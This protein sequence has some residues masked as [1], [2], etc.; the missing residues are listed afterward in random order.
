MARRLFGFKKDTGASFVPDIH[1]ESEDQEHRFQRATA[2]NTHLLPDSTFRLLWD[3]VLFLATLYNAVV[4]PL[5]LFVFQRSYE[6]IFTVDTVLDIFFV[7]AT[8][9][10]FFLYYVDDDTGEIITGQ[11]EIRART[12]SSASFYI[13]ATACLPLL[14]K[15]I[16]SRV[17]DDTSRDGLVSVYV[18]RLIRIYGFPSQFDQLK[19]LW[20]K[21][22]PINQSLFRVNVMYFYNILLITMFGCVYFGLSSLRVSTICPES[23]VF[24]DDILG[25]EMW[26]AGDSVITDVMNP[27]VC[28]KTRPD[29][30]C[31]KCPESLFFIRSVYFLVQTFFTIG[32][33]DSVVP[34]KSS[35]VEMAW[36]CFCML[37][38][39][40]MYSLMIANMSSV[41][42]NLDA[43]NMGM[44]RE[45][46]ALS[47]WSNRRSISAPLQKKVRS[48]F[49]YLERSQLGMLDQAILSELPPKLAQE[50]SDL[51]LAHLG[52][53][54]FFNPEWRTQPFLSSVA[55]ALE[56][57]FF[58]PG[59]AILAI[60]E[61]Q[62]E[63]IIMAS[64]CAQMFV[65]SRC[66]KHVDVG[67]LAQGQFLGDYNLLF[68]C[69]NQVGLNATEFSEVLVLTN[70]RFVSALNSTAHSE[71]ELPSS[72]GHF[73]ESSDPGAIATISKYDR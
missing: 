12:L 67:T 28:E 62:R 33:G 34:N 50:F 22:G 51:S 16:L 61:R 72:D 45:L 27:S 10:Q 17:L 8:V 42:A 68:D 7:L 60:S 48:L 11:R 59:S 41:L 30:A 64:G 14:L 63:L 49:S 38:G 5:R 18:L 32:F 55:T 36:A 29:L 43:V 26:V 2:L 21:Q 6:L 37:V 70:E 44:R 35:T 66:G 9:L 25:V 20:S 53:I 69:I 58:V 40:I 13:N 71:L 23:S 19:R 1:A 39:V 15:P 31:D 73:R 56:R 4:T 57:R 52:I 46:D 47:K 3:L 54:P 24:G 65:R